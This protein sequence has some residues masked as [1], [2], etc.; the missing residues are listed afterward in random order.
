[1]DAPMGYGQGRGLLVPADRGEAAMQ[2]RSPSPTGDDP[3]DI[4]AAAARL[5]AESSAV[6]DT[7][8][9]LRAQWLGM[10]AAYQAPE[11]D[12]VVSAM[13]RPD[14][15]ARL[16][17]ETSR[18]VEH[19]LCRYA[20]RLQEI[21][22]WSLGD[23]PE[24]EVVQLARRQ[25]EQTCAAAIAALASEYPGTAV[26]RADLRVA[27]RVVDR[28]PTAPA[29]GIRDR[30]RGGSQW[31]GFR[32][33]TDGDVVQRSVYGLEMVGFTSS[34]YA[35]WMVTVE[36][37]VFRPRDSFGRIVS[38]GS[39][40]PAQRMWAGAGRF[41]TARGLS[42]VE[43]LRSFDPE[44]S[45]VAKGHR[46]AAHARWSRTATAL[47]RGS[48]AV[49][50]V[51]T[52]WNQWRSTAGQATD[53]RIGRTATTTAATGSGAWAGGQAGAWLGGAVG[54]AVLPGAGTV[55][56]AAVGGVLGG[57]AGSEAGSWVG[58]RLE[59]HGAAAGDS[60]GDGM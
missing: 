46:G 58:A 17:L 30:S 4:R 56:G 20:D 38:A 31:L 57:V 25:A 48:T 1:M 27:S 54:T 32:P 18:A 14:D 49:G 26:R 39:L 13:D 15:N 51:G 6:R 42:R 22:C 33:P 8:T 53:V 10:A 23:V 12:A 37:G 50:V 52:G 40:T 28:V 36:H 45:V 41:S 35:S 16:A 7:A 2:H 44:G 21:R 5:V 43:R 19:A 24:D 47:G 59:G 29:T 11:A 55:I 34:A 60:V 9:T 3:A